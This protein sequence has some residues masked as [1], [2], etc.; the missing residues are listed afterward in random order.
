MTYPQLEASTTIG[1][2]LAVARPFVPSASA[3]DYMMDAECSFRATPSAIY[4][5]QQV[6]QR[7]VENDGNMVAKEIWREGDIEKCAHFNNAFK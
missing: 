1:I 2:T 4:K 6:L 7:I 5:L 3:S